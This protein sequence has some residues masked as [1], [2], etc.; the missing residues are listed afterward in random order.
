MLENNIDSY[1]SDVPPLPNNHLAGFRADWQTHQ[2]SSYSNNDKR[3]DTFEM[4]ST[5]T[6]PSLGMINVLFRPRRDSYYGHH[7][8]RSHSAAV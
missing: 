7:D 6:S 2:S 1:T 3:W 5:L 4:V 8:D